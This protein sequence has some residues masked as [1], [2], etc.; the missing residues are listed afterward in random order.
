MQL[1][2]ESYRTR[3]IVLV[4]AWALA[5]FA[6]FWH[7]AS[8]RDYLALTGRLGLRG[9]TDA[10]TPLKQTYPVFAA[11]AQTWVRHALS[12]TEGHAVQL[13]NTTID[14]APDGREVHWNSAWAWT[15]AGAGWIYHLF[16]GQPLANSVERAT[17]WVTPVALLILIMIL[18]AWA[19]RRAGLIAGLFL[20]SAMACNNR[21]LEGFFPAYV[22]HHGLLTVAVLGTTL[23]AILMGGGWW[24]ET[25]TGGAAI[26]PRSPKVARAA[27]VFSAIS[28]ACGMWVSAASVIPAIAIVGMAG[29]AALVVQGRATCRQGVSFDADAWRIWGRVGATACLFFY[30][31]EYFPRHLGLRLEV[32]HPFH[33]LAWLGGGE[34]IAQFGERWLR[35]D[36]QHLANPIQLLWPLFAVLLVPVTILIGGAKVMTFFDPFMSRLHNDYIQEFLPLWRTLRGFDAQTTFQIVVVDSLP[37]IA[38]IASLTYWRRESPIVLWFATFV[39]GLLTAMAWWQSRWQLNA[40]GAQ[41][42]LALAVV[43]CWTVP[44][45]PLARWL[46]AAIVMGLL[47]LPGGILRIVGTSRD[48]NA[49]IVSSKDATLALARDVATALRASQPEG[50]ITM[51]ASPNASTMVGYY[52]RFKTLGTLYWENGAGLKAAAAIF[53]AQSDEEA[54]KLLR[55]HKVTHIAILS[56]ENFIQQYYELLHPGQSVEQLTAGIKASFGYKLYVQKAVP[57]WLQM[58]PYKV[59]DDLKSLNISVMLFKVNFKQTLPEAYYNL[60]LTQISID[61]IEEADR[62]L[63]TLVKIAPKASEPWLRKG[64]IAIAR[65]DWA[66]AA[67]Y[68]LTG[69]PLAPE[70][71]RSRLYE[72][73]AGAFYNNHQHALAIRIY[74]AGLAERRDPN[75]ACYLA[76]V[77]AT[78]TEDSLRNGKE[79]LDLAK[80]AIETDPNSPS[81]LNALA[82]ALAETGRL[83]EA[84]DACDRAVAS[85]RMRNQ[86]TVAQVFEQRLSVL[87]AGKPLRN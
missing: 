3:W 48:L 83:A 38:A 29:L 45:R 66:K 30:L 62:T 76:F 25:H 7:A 47:Y 44:R 61:A 15:I 86:S 64:E 68:F 55:E 34:L 63:E 72:N 40:S 37:L 77:L 52:G 51:L 69:I 10:T 33:A 50:E 53:S 41:V 6:L 75:L 31:L 43:A 22:D 58:I 2:L 85:A 59:P 80:Q 36:D 82:A 54:A 23:G 78:S 67:D 11:D 74:R 1:T 21:I 16:T 60:A 46:V 17:V 49:R 65:H 12:L 13:R 18:S 87:K 70:A 84:V 81:Y 42:C 32:N 71:E 14:N 57:Q 27:A 20:V 39:A 8:V 5:G 9:A 24:Q 26:L 79:A 28:G 35:E 56:E 73:A 4:T 19:T